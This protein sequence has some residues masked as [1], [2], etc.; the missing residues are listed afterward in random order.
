MGLQTTGQ[1]LKSFFKNQKKFRIK[2]KKRRQSIWAGNALKRPWKDSK[3]DD[4]AVDGCCR[5][6][7]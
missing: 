7:T 3:K 6:P 5:C 4:Y 1:I 2:L